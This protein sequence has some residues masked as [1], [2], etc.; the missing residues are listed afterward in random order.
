MSVAYFLSVP[1]KNKQISILY[2]CVHCERYENTEVS[3][4]ISPVVIRLKAVI[5][6]LLNITY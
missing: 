4:R 1:P 5:L 2:I 6:L 3:V